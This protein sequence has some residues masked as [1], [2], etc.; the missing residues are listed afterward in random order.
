MPKVDIPIKRLMQKRPE[1]WIAY[2]LPEQ[3]D[4]LFDVV[5]PEKVPKAESRM[6]AL[7]KLRDGDEFYYLHFEPQGYFDVAFPARMLRYRADIWE[8]TLSEGKDLLQF[9][10]RCF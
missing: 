10:R 2:L 9:D 3:E 8:Y 5:K 4:P 1:D 7:W 6:D